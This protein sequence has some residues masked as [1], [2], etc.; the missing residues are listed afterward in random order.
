LVYPKKDSSFFLAHKIHW[1]AWFG[2]IHGLNEWLDMFIMVRAMELT[3]FLE[4]FRMMTSG[5]FWCRGYF[6]SKFKVP[7]L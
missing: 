4:F 5:L 3:V 2:I 7:F 6:K 1:V